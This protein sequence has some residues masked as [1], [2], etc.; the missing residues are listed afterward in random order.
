MKSIHPYILIVSVLVLP[1]LP[2]L[3]EQW[4]HNSPKA[5]RAPGAGLLAGAHI[6]RDLQP[7]D[8]RYLLTWTWWL[9]SSLYTKEME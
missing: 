5:P 6:S 9:I 4:E 8:G 2:F 1:I 7:R 3:W